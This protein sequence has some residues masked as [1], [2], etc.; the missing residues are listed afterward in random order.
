MNHKAML[1]V[2]GLTQGRLSEKSERLYLDLAFFS[3]ACCNGRLSN[4]SPDLS[5]FFFWQLE[6]FADSGQTS[7]KIDWAGYGYAFADMDLDEVTPENIGLSH[8][9]SQV[10]KR[11]YPLFKK[12][13]IRL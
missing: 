11:L 8:L 10:Q 13:I 2:L 5:K 1:S 9:A 3:A 7:K 4:V 12:L 6:A